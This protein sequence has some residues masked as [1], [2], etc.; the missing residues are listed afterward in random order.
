MRS[1]SDSPIIISGGGSVHI[2]F[3]HTIFEG[4]NGRHSHKQKKIMRVEITDNNTGQVHQFTAPDN[5][6][7][8]I[9]IDTH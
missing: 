8:T 9:R 2:E 3:D 7:C 5:G 4:S 6:N 1:I